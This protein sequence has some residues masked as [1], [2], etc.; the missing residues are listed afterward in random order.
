MLKSRPKKSHVED[1]PVEIDDSFPEEDNKI[2]RDKV[3]IYILLGV[4]LVFGILAYSI[5]SNPKKIELPKNEIR[6]YN[7]Y[8]FEQQEGQF[9][10]TKLSIAD[11]SKGWKRDYDMYFHYT[12]DQV[13]WIETMKDSKNNSVAPNLFLNVDRVYITTDPDYPASVVLGGVE[14]AKVL[15][16]IY[17]KEVKGAVTRYKN[18]SAVPVITC[19]NINATQRIIML[20]LGNETKIY[21]SNGCIIVKGKDAF[22]LIKACE[23]LTYEMLKI[24]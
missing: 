14:I 7:G 3:L 6:T 20:E 24:L 21:N 2:S 4:L 12:P 17:D 16:K 1:I 15:G 9:W 19:D 13:E 22:D 8:V 10:F 11:K 5:M 23:R 18:N